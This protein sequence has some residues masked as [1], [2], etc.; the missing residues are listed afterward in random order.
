MVPLLEWSLT[1]SNAASS[2]SSSFD[3]KLHQVHVVSGGSRGDG[4]IHPPTG[5]KH[6]GLER[7]FYVKTAN[8]SAL[9]ADYCS[10]SKKINTIM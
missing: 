1:C 7:S 5:L 8:F 4:G 10:T 2:S 3:F 6:R 9:R